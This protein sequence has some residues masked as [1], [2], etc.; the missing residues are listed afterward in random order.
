MKLKN[1]EGNEKSPVND[2]LTAEFWKHFSN[3]LAPVL[4]DAYNA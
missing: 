1:S 4:L 2:G 3:K